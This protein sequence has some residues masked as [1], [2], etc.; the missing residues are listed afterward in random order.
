ML[1]RLKY[2]FVLPFL[3][4]AYWAIS[5]GVADAFSYRV[6]RAESEWLARGNVPSL[7]AWNQARESIESAI[8]LNT[9]N[10]NYP[11]TM[12]RLY[13]WRLYVK[14]APIG[15]FEE[16]QKFLSKGIDY[17]RSSIEKRPTWPLAWATLLEMK[18]LG[19]VLDG[20]YWLAWDST[21]ALGPWDRASQIKLMESGLIHWEAFGQEQQK[22]VI[23][24]FVGM[25][26]KPE[27]G[28]E[29]IL[30][31][32]EFGALPLF[33]DVVPAESATDLFKEN[34][35]KLIETIGDDALAEPLPIDDASSINPETPVSNG[36]SSSVENNSLLLI[37]P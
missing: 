13:I 18:S 15:S 23:D 4:L 34:C 32:N 17:M 11:E 19:G 10:P 12:G 31:A 16:H 30:I 20:E 2:L 24:V 5:W 22:K 7:D 9:F 33:C 3:F 27:T 37:K 8:S 28:S 26:A 14:D 21:V 35:A 1:T 29:G 25:L 36:P 6:V